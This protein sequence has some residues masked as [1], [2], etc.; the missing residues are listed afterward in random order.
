L[1]KICIEWSAAKRFCLLFTQADLPAFVPRRRIGSK[2]L[3]AEKAD[4]APTGDTA[5]LDS[6]RINE[7][8]L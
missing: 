8:M 2:G 7:R 3:T 6:S 4:A 5:S 1:Q